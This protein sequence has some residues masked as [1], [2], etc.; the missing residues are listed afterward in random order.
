MVK[1]GGLT[2]KAPIDYAYDNFFGRIAND[3]VLDLVS[4]FW[5]LF[6]MGI[7]LFALDS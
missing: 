7:S 4:Y 2:Y 6:I 5:L 1:D 3:G